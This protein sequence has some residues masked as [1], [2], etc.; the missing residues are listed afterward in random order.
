M[1]E[2]IALARKEPGKLT[3]ASAG[4]GTASHIPAEV[5]KAQTGTDILMVPYRGVAEAMTDLLAGRIDMFFVGTQIALQQ[6]QTGK[7]RA[8]AVTGAKRWKG[9]PDV[10]TM[11]EGGLKDFDIVNWFGLWLPAGAPSELVNRL[12]AEMAKALAEP[13]I[14]QQFDALGLEGVG[15]K[16]DAFATFVAKELTST[17]AIARKI[18]GAKK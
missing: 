8:L 17:S 14:K 10:P 11:Q 16:P 15:M 5:M 13:D 4:I 2:L 9:M 12:Q 3:Y 1:P 6:V 7:V 18:S